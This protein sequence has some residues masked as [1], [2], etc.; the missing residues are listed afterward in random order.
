[1][2]FFLL[3]VIALAAAFLARMAWVLIPASGMF[4]SLT[5]TLVDQCRRVTVA[6]GTED[7]TID[8]DKARAYISS[9]D[10]RAWFAGKAGPTPGPARRGRALTAGPRPGPQP[11]HRQARGAVCRYQPA[12][13]VV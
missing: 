7:V 2:R 1:M 8:R 11:G 12:A 13:D 4:A 9:T 3:S 5:P 6:P 10:R